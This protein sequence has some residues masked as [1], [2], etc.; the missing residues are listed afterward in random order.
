MGT[1]SLNGGGGEPY[2]KKCAMS[3]SKKLV[4]CMCNLCLSMYTHITT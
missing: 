3:L 1:I 2:L 4:A